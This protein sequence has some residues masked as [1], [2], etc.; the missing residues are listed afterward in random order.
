[1]LRYTT[2]S[3]AKGQLSIPDSITVH[4]AR[5]TRLIAA[6]EEWARVFLNIDSLEDTLDD[7]PVSSPVELPPN[8]TSAILMHV[9]AEFDRDMQNFN[10]LIGRATDLLWP[11][12]KEL[13]V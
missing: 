6:A 11:Y 12:R 7:S 5:I 13:G 8:I 4:D 10:V 1:M 2:L 9:E 3:D